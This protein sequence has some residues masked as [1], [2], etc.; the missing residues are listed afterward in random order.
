MLAPHFEFFSATPESA[1]LLKPYPQL[2]AWLT[3]M[4]NRQSMRNT[5]WERLKQTA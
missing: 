2:D 3:R 4:Q 1:A 5:G